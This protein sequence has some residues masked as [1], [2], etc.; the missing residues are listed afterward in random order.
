MGGAWLSINAGIEAAKPPWLETL[1]QTL[2][3]CEARLGLSLT[4][5]VSTTEGTRAP[6]APL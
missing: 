1:L 3:S 5:Q 4:L 2:S 6:R